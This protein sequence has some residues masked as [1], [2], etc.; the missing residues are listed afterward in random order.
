MPDILGYSE[1]NTLTSC[2]RK[3]WY[4]NDQEPIADD[5]EKSPQLSKGTALHRLIAGWETGDETAAYVEM[6]A[7]IDRGDL[8][9]ETA[10][11]TEW[12]FD[13]YK[14]FYGGQRLRIVAH[15]L[16]LLARIPGTRTWFGTRGVD[17]IVQVPRSVDPEHAG[18]WHL[19]R[20]TMKDWQRLIVLPVDQQVT[21]AQ[22][23]LREAG[24][25]V[26][27]TIF[28]A[29]RTYR[30]VDVKPT[31][32]EVAEKLQAAS[33]EWWASAG[34]TRR[35]EVVRAYQVEMTH[36]AP[37]EDSFRRVFLERTPAQVDGQLAELRAVA[38]RWRQLRL[39]ATPHR[40][41]DRSCGWCSF[42]DDC[43]RSL[44]TNDDSR[45]ID[46]V[47]ARAAR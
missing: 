4:I 11:D 37:L 24:W 17:S 33:P 42:K 13:R 7:M 30:F 35:K 3:W 12:L 22:W 1:A 29:I 38:S 31:Q 43:W 32:A 14:R 6:Q 27:G 21:T 25:K 2:E 19:E 46:S 20:K 15:E 23:L 16:P 26:R 39:G 44:I 28:D 36:E 47:R 10:A 18:L 5:A 41:I 9:K 40:N 45:L 8:D 34:A